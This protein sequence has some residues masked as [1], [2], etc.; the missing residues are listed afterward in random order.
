MET[1]RDKW[2]MRPF[3]ALFFALLTFFV[4]VLIAASV[5]LRGAGDMTKRIIL[6]CVCLFTTLTFFIYKYYLSID[7]EYDIIRDEMGMGGFNWWGELPL[8]LCN[9]NMMLIPIA[10]LLKIRPL[11]SF[12]FFAAPLGA[13]AALTMPG[14]GFEGYSL[15]LP[16]MMGFF[17][18]HFMIFIEGLA[19][20]TFRLYKPAFRDIPLTMLTAL[21]TLL[22]V[23]AI[24]L[25]LRWTGVYPNANYFYSIESENNAILDMF[26]RWL[27]VP[28]L[29][30]MP[31]IGI[32]AFYMFVITGIFHISDVLRLK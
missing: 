15:L 8:H 26:Y 12:C 24:N 11:E 21:I 9:I 6:A 5:A 25:I 3:N 27:P 10:V 2:I 22:G 31:C 23:S 32:L 7:K 1:N 14:E 30:I 28:V 4:A 29:Y 18:T 13:L 16:R 19:I 20:T 17:G